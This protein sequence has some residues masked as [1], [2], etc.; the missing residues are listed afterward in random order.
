MEIPIVQKIVE[1]L[2]KAIGGIIDFI[3]G[4]IEPVI[5]IF[6]T[7]YEVVKSFITNAIAIVVGLDN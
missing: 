1:M 4:I 6:T 5:R 3:K 2:K 7:V